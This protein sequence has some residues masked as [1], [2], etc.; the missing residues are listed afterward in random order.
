MRAGTVGM[1]EMRSRL[2]RR[3]AQFTADFMIASLLPDHQT[4]DGFRDEPLDT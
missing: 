2:V 1:V 3:F 4:A